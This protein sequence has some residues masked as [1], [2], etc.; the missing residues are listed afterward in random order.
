MF[1]LIPT[2]VGYIAFAVL[3]CLILVNRAY[4]RGYKAGYKVGHINAT[5]SLSHVDES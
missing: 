2:T 1:S 3:L 4:H 5:K